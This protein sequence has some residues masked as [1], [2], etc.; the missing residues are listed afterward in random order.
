MIFLFKKILFTLIFN[1]T[2]FLVLII[3]VQNSHI[4]SKVNLI[5]GESVSL[6]ISFI[7]GL[8]FIC[9]SISGNLL[10]INSKSKKVN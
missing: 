7:V 6:P 10:N 8:S 3:G 4:K 2:L 1:S 9:G 5:I